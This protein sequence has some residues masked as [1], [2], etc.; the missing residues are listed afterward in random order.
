MS[1]ADLLSEVDLP[2]EPGSLVE[3]KLRAIAG[4]L[5]PLWAARCS[6]AEAMVHQR[7]SSQGGYVGDRT[8]VLGHKDGNWLGASLEEVVDLAYGDAMPTIIERGLRRA[9]TP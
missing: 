6:V 4:V 9:K 2:V 8:V 1:T 5:G 3:T 7:I